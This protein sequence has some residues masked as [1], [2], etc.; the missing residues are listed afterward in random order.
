MRLYS[1]KDSCSIEV[2]YALAILYRFKR[3]V[4]KDPILFPILLNGSH[5]VMFHPDEAS[6]TCRFKIELFM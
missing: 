3:A 4:E 1:F 5:G 2:L 6:E